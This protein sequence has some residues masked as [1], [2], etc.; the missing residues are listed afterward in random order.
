LGTESKYYKEILSKLDKLNKRESLLLVAIGAQ[1][2]LMVFIL[3]FTS[4][5][6]L[7]MILNH[8]SLLRTV[9]FFI[10]VLISLGVLAL[11]LFIPL[12]RYL[13]LI[14]AKSYSETAG[15]VG[16]SFPLIRDDLL[17]AMQ[18][19][20]VD[21][22]KKI[23]SPALIDAAFQ[24]VYERTSALKFESIIDF[25]KAK[26]LLLYFSIVTLIAGLLFIFIPGLQSASY[27]LMNFNHEFVPPPKYAF[28][29]QPG[30]AKITKGDNVHFS[31]KVKGPDPKEVT[32]SI[33]T[34]EQTEFDQTRLTPD[35]MGT[36][37][38]RQESVRSSFEYFASAN[39]INSEKFFIEVIDRPI[40]KTLDVTVNAPAYSKIPQLRQKDNGNIT[41]LKGSN[42]IL[43]LS[44][45][46]NLQDAKLLFR[47]TSEVNLKIN[48]LQAE[49]NFRLL[50]DNSYKIILSDENGNQNVNPI[51][52]SLKV[53]Y[54][55]F[56]SIEM[57][58]PN[59][60]V[61]LGNDNRLPL[62]A[63]IND[64]YGF[65]KLLLHYRLSASRYEPPQKD[66]R[67]IEIPFEKGVKESN[68]DYFWNLSPLSLGTDDVVTYYLEVFD[69][70]NVS[71]PKS[72]KTSTFTVRVPSLDEILAKADETHS[73]AEQE[74]S[75]TLKEAEELQRT[76]EKIDQDLK[77]DKKE[78]T[79]EEKE[80]IEKALDKYEELQNK[81]DNV[82]EQL[83]KMQQ[84][85]NENQLLSKETLEKYME[86]QELMNE[87]TSEEMK[88]ALEEMRNLLEDLNR[89]M[90]QEA[91][92]NLKLDEERFKRSIERTMNL[93]KRIQVE[94]KIDELLKR[95][96]KLA[97]E[98]EEIKNQTKESDLNNQNERNDLSEKQDDVT[99]ELND[100]SKELDKLQEKMN[101]LKDMPKEELEK[102][103]EEFE[104]QQNEQT[105]EEASEKIKQNQKQMAQ[106]QQSKLSQNMSQMN[107]KMQELQD[108]MMQMNQM[109]TFT[110][111]MK[112]LDNLV[113]LSKEQEELKKESQN[114]ETNSS[115]LQSR[116]QKQNSISKNL[117]KIL[118]QMSKLSQKTFAVTPEMGKA[119]G[120]AKREMMKSIQSLQNRNTGMASINQ[121]DAMKS[122][123]EAATLMKG[124]ME[125]MMQVGGQGGMM[126]LMQQ[127]NQMAGQQMNLNNL[128]QMLQGQG[129]LSPQQQAELQR[130]GQQQ[131]L[132]KKSLEQLNR[133][134]RESGQSK[135][136]SSNLEN[137]LKQMEEVITDMNTEKL[138]DQLIQKQERILSKLLD[139]Q[140][141]INER[142]FE[143]ERESNTG[144]NTV[145]ESPA[146]LNLNSDKGKDKIKDE[147]N[148]A[149]EEGYTK[150]YETL[151]RKYFEAIQKEE[152]NN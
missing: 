38:Y 129:T 57:I 140:R 151:I 100:F 15:K 27:R 126:S 138:D 14:K 36:Y 29:I 62:L 139:A 4:F 46:K 147:L 75:Q 20:S 55:A 13:N 60:N 127:L 25:K 3:L 54:D 88:K 124:S 137:I 71:G 82:G 146:G 78:L 79:W 34:I 110:D 103:R 87:L 50:K 84:E 49:G 133:E 7:E 85:L 89:Q 132:I 113:T 43:K 152:V 130:L 77:Q 26:E 73:R 5:S 107:R 42:V 128:T 108:A 37:S 68:V 119:L 31:I 74:L 53:L 94:Q 10:I 41:S 95:T 47:D 19:V 80:K 125:A 39:N 106:Q 48:S 59:Q 24:N 141:S 98:Q 86:L 2:F 131:Q 63:K 118:D 23:Y 69:N 81:V 70:D 66:F 67:S 104:K 112:I 61:T 122:L 90:T 109:Q 101:E 148:R 35:S 21:S 123:N 45:T 144:E 40:I 18:L 116:T 76:L 32:L 149:I 99:K 105:S 33:K 11:F 17:N 52:Y 8:S 51:T 97:K 91:L 115:D 102:L 114:R 92:Q 6:F 83:Q 120:D 135:S 142:D 117:D 16:E 64:D 145:R 56:P 30:N 93:L 1:A 136:L 121:G 58:A 44:S 22:V 150:D 28:E 134:A 111:M 96:E 143:K 9:I 12:L 65:S 72:A